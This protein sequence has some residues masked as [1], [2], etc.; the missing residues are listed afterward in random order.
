[1]NIVY[2]HHLI[3]LV[4]DGC[5]W[6]SENIPITNILIHRITKLP[7]KGADL[8]KDFGGKIKE[9]KLVD[10]MKTKFGLI[11]KLHR[12]SIH[13]IQDQA[14]QFD[15]EIL[16]RK[17]KRKCCVDEVLVLVVSLAT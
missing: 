13:S 2:V 17:I 3:A 15:A 1:M 8:D 11:K 5:L 7:Y 6:I 16:V 14:V 12:Y 9:K 10:K 4:H